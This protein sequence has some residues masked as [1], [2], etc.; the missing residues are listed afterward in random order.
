[1]TKKP[2][3]VT[4]NCKEAPSMK[5]NIEEMHLMYLQWNAIKKLKTKW[6]TV[7]PKWNDNNE[8]STQKWDPT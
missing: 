1:M 7:H 6:K 3:W 8:G 4:K 2:K 5:T